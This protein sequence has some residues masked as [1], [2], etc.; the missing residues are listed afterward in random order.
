MTRVSVAVV[1]NLKSAACTDK[2]EGGLLMAVNNLDRSRWYM[3]NVLWF[4]G[5]NSKTDRENNFGFL[6]SE[7][8]NELFFHKNEISRNYTPADNAP[9][10]FREGTGKNG[11]LRLLMFTFLIKQMRRRLSSLLNISGLLLRRALISLVGVIV[12][13]LLIFSLSPLAK[14]L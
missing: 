2:A 3:G 12:T 1:K 14:G 6:L 4:G 8:G 13:A 11:N 7:N 10:L 5:Y 9:V